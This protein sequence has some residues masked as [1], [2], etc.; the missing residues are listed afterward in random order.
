GI[1]N[2]YRS[3][4]L[5]LAGILPTRLVSDIQET[6]WSPLLASIKKV[7]K[8]AVKLRGM[9]DGD[10]RDTD[11]LPG[12]FQRTLFVYGR[13]GLPCKKCDTI[14]ERKKIGQRSIFYCSR[15]QV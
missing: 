10:F 13:T 1:G 8:K 14:I 6:E 7:L 4:A 3:E 15:C 9:S 5:F 2:I 11:G 12:R